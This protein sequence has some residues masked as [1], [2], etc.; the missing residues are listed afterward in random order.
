M[1]FYILTYLLLLLIVQSIG[2]LRE[3]KENSRQEVCRKEYELYKEARLEN[4]KR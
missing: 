2:D 3:A 1:I 4:I